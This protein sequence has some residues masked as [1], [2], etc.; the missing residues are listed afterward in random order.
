M[1]SALSVLLVA[2]LGLHI[3]SHE[4]IRA[5]PPVEIAAANDHS[6]FL[7]LSLALR[8]TSMSTHINNNAVVIVITTS[9]AYDP[10]CLEHSVR[11]PPLA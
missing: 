6:S 7:S 5:L 11:A 3:S 9:S 1:T 10:L 4:E 8:D 2:V